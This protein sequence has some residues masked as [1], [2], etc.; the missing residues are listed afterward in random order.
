MSNSDSFISEVSEEVRRERF[1]AFLRRYGWIIALAVIVVVGGAIANEWMKARA[2][3]HAVEQGEAL[4]AALAEADPQARAGRLAALA[5][6]AEAMPVARLAEAGALSEAGD[7]EGAAAVL[8]ALA[9]D[10]SQPE[11]YRAVA[12]LQRI[13][14]LGHALPRSERLAA[15]ETLAQEGAPM[16]LLALEQRALLHLEAGDAEAAIADLQTIAATP[17]A[18]EALAARVRQLIIAAGGELGGTAAPGGASGG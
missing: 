12:G 3:A 13:M 16:R 14:L 9:E 4:R 8:A 18:P 2:R 11:I 6:S 5:L 10:G 7:A 17:A 1:Y 15:I